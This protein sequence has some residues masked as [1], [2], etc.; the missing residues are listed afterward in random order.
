MTSIVETWNSHK[1]PSESDAENIVAIIIT[2]ATSLRC[3]TALVNAVCKLMK[4]DGI[5]EI[6]KNNTIDFLK[7]IYQ[8]YASEETITVQT[9]WNA[10]ITVLRNKL[11]IIK[12][13]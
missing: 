6:R 13:L 4:I 5:N 8:Q 11:V 3:L 9:L 12:E 2:K 7:Y 10:S 1:P